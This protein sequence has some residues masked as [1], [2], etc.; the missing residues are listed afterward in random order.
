MNK[1]RSTVVA[2]IGY[3]AAMYLDEIIDDLYSKTTISKLKLRSNFFII[4]DKIYGNYF[5]Q[6]IIKYNLN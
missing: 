5:H 6:K 1:I 3:D 4:F 2:S